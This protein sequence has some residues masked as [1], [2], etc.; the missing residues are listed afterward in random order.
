MNNPTKVENAH[1]EKVKINSSITTLLLRITKFIWALVLIENLTLAVVAW[2][3]WKNIK[4]GEP[5][6]RT[7]AHFLIACVAVGIATFFL[8]QFRQRHEAKE[9]KGLKS[10]L[11]NAK[12]AIDE[13][14]TA[15][16][17]LERR[18]QNFQEETD[19]NLRYLANPR[20]DAYDYGR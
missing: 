18:Q 7:S 5:Y 9:S 12:E 6:A 15:M 13:H 10:E 3:D 14:T 4:A 16:E 19:R 20:S 17:D 2:A 1:A 11:A 8:D